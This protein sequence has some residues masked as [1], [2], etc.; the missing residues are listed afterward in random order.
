MNV[1]SRYVEC[2]ALRTKMLQ[3][4]QNYEYYMMSEVIEP[5]WHILENNLKTVSCI[6]VGLFVSAIVI[7]MH[8][9]KLSV[10]KHSLITKNTI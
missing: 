8:F 6:D 4:V 9:R 2:S 5:Y 10:L 3:F 7:Q 1:S